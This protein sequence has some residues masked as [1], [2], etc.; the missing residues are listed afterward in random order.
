MA[1]NTRY[2]GGMEILKKAAGAPKQATTGLQKFGAGLKQKLAEAQ[3]R[4]ESSPRYKKSQK[5]ISLG[6]Y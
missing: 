6:N 4:W 3:G 5:A 2:M 1:K